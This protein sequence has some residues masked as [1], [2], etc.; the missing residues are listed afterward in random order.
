MEIRRV[1]EA[2]LFTVTNCP[3]CGKQYPGTITVQLLPG[4]NML[5]TQQRIE[6]ASICH[7]CDEWA[8][9]ELLCYHLNVNLDRMEA[10]DV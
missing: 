5:H 3:I 4:E 2:H 10:R 1:E 8:G 9:V 7:D 6:D